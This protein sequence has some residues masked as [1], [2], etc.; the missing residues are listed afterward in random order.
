MI[1]RQKSV[2]I[3]V[4]ETADMMMFKKRQEINGGAR[5]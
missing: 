5:Q 1:T 2:A 3:K 4:Y